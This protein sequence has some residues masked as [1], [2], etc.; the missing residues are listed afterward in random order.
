[1]LLRVLNLFLFYVDFT[2]NTVRSGEFVDSDHSILRD[3]LISHNVGIRISGRALITQGVV[4]GTPIFRIG[5]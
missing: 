1:M 2:Y 4:W 3:Y 5:T